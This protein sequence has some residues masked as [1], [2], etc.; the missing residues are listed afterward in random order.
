MTE[1]KRSSEKFNYFIQHYWEY[2]LELESE[3]ISTKK[4]VDFN[5]D[6]YSTYSVEYLKLFQ[7]VCSEIDVVGKMMAS[8]CNPSFKATDKNNTLFKWWY[9]IQN[10]YH[11]VESHF[12]PINPNPKPSIFSMQE[13]KCIIL[14]KM[15]FAPWDAFFVVKNGKYKL[16]NESKDLQW[17]KDYNSVK[18]QRE[19]L[20]VRDSNYKLANLKNVMFAFSALYVL[21]KAFMDS[22]GDVDDL[23]AFTDFSKLFVKR[24]AY[25]YR[26]MD[27]LFHEEE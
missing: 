15:W 12:T 16:D 9:E 19:L 4:Y 26:E 8:Y 10:N 23:Q 27:I 21:E 1:L 25:T 3:F 17:W 5:P 13:Y 24:R 11:L 22:V 2:F 18:H 6:N 20:D 14:G 7:A